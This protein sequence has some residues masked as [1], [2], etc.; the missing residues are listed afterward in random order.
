MPQVRNLERWLKSCSL[1][2]LV[3]KIILELKLELKYCN[4]SLSYILKSN[5]TLFK[6]KLSKQYTE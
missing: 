2:K 6:K 5:K 1:V 4:C 3:L